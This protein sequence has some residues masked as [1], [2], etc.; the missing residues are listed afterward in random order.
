LQNDLTELE[1]LD[2][3]RSRLCVSYED[4]KRALDQTGGDVVAALAELEKS[5][6]DLFSLSAEILDDVQKLIG[7]A[8]AKKLRIKFGGRL[9]KEIPLALTA[10]TAFILGFAVV[11]VTKAS[12]EIE[13]EQQLETQV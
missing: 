5:G 6:H 4:A 2:A 11:L 12:L 10:T 9:V 8:S 7:A 13:R 3:I 1:K